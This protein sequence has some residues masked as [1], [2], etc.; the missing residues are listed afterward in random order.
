MNAYDV[1]VVLW[2]IAIVLGAI[3]WGRPL[4]KKEITMA[5]PPQTCAN[6]VYYLPDETHEDTTGR[7]RCHPP[8]VVNGSFLGKSP[9]VHAEDWCG[10]WKSA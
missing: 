2:T 10:D 7:C 5:K 9:I 8:V 4:S 1:L 6:C 3:N